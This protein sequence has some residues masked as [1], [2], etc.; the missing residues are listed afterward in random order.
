MKKAKVLAVGPDGRNQYTP[1]PDA[2]AGHRSANG[3]HNAGPFIGYELHT[4]VQARDIRWTNY[5]DRTILEAKAPNVIT[6]AVLVPAGTH[7]AKSVVPALIEEKA[8]GHDNK[9]VIWDPGYSLCRPETTTYPLNKAGIA[10]T[11]QLVMSQRG[12]RPFSKDA[13]LTD[14][15]LFSRLMPERLRDLAAAPMEA[16]G[17]YRAAYEKPFNQRAHWR[18]VRHSAP[19]HNGVT[20]RKCPFCAGHLKSRSF[21]KTMR[22]A[23]TVP[24]VFLPSKTTSC[25][26]GTVSAPPSDI[27]LS[28]KIPLGPRPGGSR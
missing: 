12:I 18:L 24:F 8:A 6:T 2:R 1:D 13:L 3:R 16:T 20:R 5:T 17:A 22:R 25:C 7:R 27:P 4:V 19:D 21:P 11:F 23:A 15:Q 28:Q 14:G 26:S 9:D 10:Q